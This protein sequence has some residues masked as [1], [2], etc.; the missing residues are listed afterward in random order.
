MFK[1]LIGLLGARK[2]TPTK[3]R[4]VPRAASPASKV[5]ATRASPI[6][7]AKAFSRPGLLDRL[8]LPDVHESHDE[9]AWDEW[10]HSSMEID[11]RLGGLSAHDSVKVKD[12]AP[13]QVGELDPF[14]SVRT[15]KR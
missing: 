9:S 2:T 12:G 14:A 1:F 11:S 3:A 4:K 15:R 10:E 5:G 7:E 6:E 8:P 13:S